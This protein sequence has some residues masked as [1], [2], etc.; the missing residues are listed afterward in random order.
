M[1]AALSGKWAVFS[2]YF[3]ATVVVVLGDAG[4]SAEPVCC[5][6]AGITD[7]MPIANDTLK[8]SALT[9]SRTFCGFVDLS[10]VLPFG[11]NVMRE[12]N[13]MAMFIDEL[14]SISNTQS[15]KRLA[16]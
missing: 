13:R 8:P 7:C 11:R 6:S 10:M 2:P 14:L 3:S 1:S 16:L 9:K 12:K 4:V 5:S 15:K